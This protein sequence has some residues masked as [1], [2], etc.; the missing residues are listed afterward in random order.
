MRAANKLHVLGIL[1]EIGGAKALQAIAAA[2]TDSNPDIK[3]AASRLLGQWP[4]AD[5]APA[6]LDLAKTAGEEKY[7]IRA[8]RGYL[9][10]ARQ[11]DVPEAQRV[12]MCRAALA[13][14]TRDE[15][16][17]IATE[18]LAIHP[19]LGMLQ[20]AVEAGKT[21]AL[22][23]DATRSAIMIAQKIGDGSDEVRKMLTQLGIEAGKVEILRAEYGSGTEIKDV[24]ATLQ[25]RVGKYPLIVFRSGNYN[26]IFSGDPAPGKAKT[27][28]IKYKIDGAPG[29]VSWPENAP[30]LLPKP[31]K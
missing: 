16:R 15:E 18:V 26:S 19:S 14:A 28:K 7:R 10:I 25:Q 23:A 22:K 11:F 27:L 6:L 2:A 21:P 4:T 13:T 9:R 31:Q 12:E 5:A 1:G 30:I 24:T 20:I 3:D 8:L 17:K 29:E